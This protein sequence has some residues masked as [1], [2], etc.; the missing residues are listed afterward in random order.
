L[1]WK[2][3]DRERYWAAHEALEPA[4]RRACAPRKWFLG[5]LI[6]GAVAVFQHRR[7]NWVGAT[8][9]LS[10]ARVKLNGFLPQYE[11]LD[12]ERFLGEIQS[13]LSGSLARLTPSQRAG[14][15]EVEN[16]VRK[17]MITAESGSNEQEIASCQ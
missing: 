13:E 11:G 10:R 6:H 7:G 17:E 2:L 16:S 8:R 9:Q 15:L 12:V 4:W 14:L 5:G 3:C 1:F